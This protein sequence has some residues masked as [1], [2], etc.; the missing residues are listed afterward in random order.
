MKW[1]SLGQ[2]YAARIGVCAAMVGLSGIGYAAGEE[3]KVNAGRVHFAM[4]ADVV[5]AYHLRGLIF[6]DD[7]MILQPWAVLNANLYSGDSESDIQAVNLKLMGWGSVHE[8]RTTAKNTPEKWYECDGFAA[9]QF[10]MFEKWMFEGGVHTISWPNGTRDAATE[11]YGVVAYNDS[12]FWKDL[13]IE[14]SGFNGFQP[15]MMLSIEMDNTFM[16]MPGKRKSGFV[17]MGIKPKF[18]LVNSGRLPVTLNLPVTVGFGLRDY[19]GTNDSSFGFA[20]LGVHTE[21]PLTMVPGDYGKWQVKA[22][23]D[24]IL[25][26]DSPRSYNDGHDSFKPVGVIGVSMAY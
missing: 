17:D 14:I 7:G 20:K 9:L 11:L 16:G 24:L 4:G 18:K 8:K 23:V 22:G 5:S 1:A 25:V 26:G 13:D 19:Y 15:W 6:E 2:S 10:A 21:M 3:N 12:E